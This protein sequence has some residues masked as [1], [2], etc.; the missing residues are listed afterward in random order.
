MAVSAGRSGN[1]ERAA[2]VAGDVYGDSAEKFNSK[3]RGVF[4]RTRNIPLFFADRIGGNPCLSAIVRIFE[5]VRFGAPLRI[6]AFVYIDRAARAAFRVNMKPGLLID[7]YG[8]DASSDQPVR[9]CPAQRRGQ[10]GETQ[11]VGDEARRQQQG[12]RG[13]DQHAFDNFL[14]G[15]LTGLE[16]LPGA[17]QGAQTLPFQ[18]L[19]A[20]YRSQ[21]DEANGPQ[22]ADMA[23][24]FEQQQH[25]QQGNDDEK[26]Q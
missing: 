26:Q 2:P 16:T 10:K 9:Y 22:A 6:L 11:G 25:L 1:P 17:Q 24:D 18:N 13:S 3:F 15:Q 5:S 14:R 19:D 20:D 4:S 8:P 12:A 7:L 21:D 23:G